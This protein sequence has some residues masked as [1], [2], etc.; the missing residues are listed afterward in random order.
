MQYPGCRGSETERFWRRVTILD[1]GCWQWTGG[2][3]SEGYGSFTLQV[4]TGQKRIQIGAHR[5]AYLHYVGLVPDRLVLDHL[6]RNRAC[7]NPLHL[8]PVTEKVNA[9]RGEGQTAK[10]ARKSHCKH[11]HKFECDNIAFETDSKGRISRRC[12]KCVRLR[13]ERKKTSKTFQQARLTIE[14][15]GSNKT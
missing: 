13:Y 8:E 10:N 11:G 15:A 9:L 2:Q 3:N 12:R 4:I 6:C 14:I 1:N 5:W 7:V